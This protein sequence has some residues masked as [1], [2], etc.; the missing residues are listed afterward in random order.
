MTFKTDLDQAFQ[1]HLAQ[2][3]ERL[4][5]EIYETYNQG[6][7]ALIKLKNKDLKIQLLND[8]GIINFEIGSIYGK[9]LFFDSE[10]IASMIRLDQTD[11]ENLSR[12]RRK[13]IIN[14]RLGLDQ[15]VEL[16]KT[17]YL[18][19]K[20]IFSEPNYKRTIKKLNKIGAERFEN[21]M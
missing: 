1:K 15:Q 11:Q 8:R 3:S 16:L 12:L 9:E 17:D 10:L 18:T 21:M 2:V 6:M 13:Q 4:N 20:E 7:G 5:F 14:N 19:L